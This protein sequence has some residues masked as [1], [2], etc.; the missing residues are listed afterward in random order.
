M[1]DLSTAPTNVD[2]IEV[3]SDQETVLITEQQVVFAT[4]AAVA[5]PPA[6]TSNWVVGAV[7]AFADALRGALASP[8]PRHSSRVSLFETRI[9]HACAG[10]WTRLLSA[11]RNRDGL[12][13][14]TRSS[15][16]SRPGLHNRSEHRGSHSLQDTQRGR[17][18]P[19]AFMRRATSATARCAGGPGG[20]ACH[21]R[22]PRPPL[23]IGSSSRRRAACGP[24]APMLP[25]LRFS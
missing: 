13:S 14:R 20:R 24:C 21:P 11:A 25:A 6:R 12:S 5:V 18:G 19:T 16:A 3:A 23:G 9:P 22:R 17:D 10:K 4:A 15:R 7:H 8:A 2:A 1:T